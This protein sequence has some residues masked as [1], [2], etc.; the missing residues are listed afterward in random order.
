[1]AADHP[2][3]GDGHGRDAEVGVFRT[4]GD[5]EQHGGGERE[6]S[7]GDAE[8]DD[9][10]PRQKWYMFDSQTM[11]LDRVSYIARKNGAEVRVETR[12]ESWEAVKRAGGGAAGGAA[13]GRERGSEAGGGRGGGRRTGRRRDVWSAVRNGSGK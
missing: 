8:R 13:G 2:R 12:W 3:S 11:L 4:D 7:G 1:M 9:K 10:A 6:P 5:G